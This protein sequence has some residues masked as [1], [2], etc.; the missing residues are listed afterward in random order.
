MDYTKDYSLITNIEVDDV[1]RL[2]YPCQ[3]NVKLTINGDVH[4]YTMFGP[5]ICKIYMKKNWEIPE[6]FKEYEAK[7][8]AETRET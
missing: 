6:H 4:D 8:L 3:H 5:A 1:C 2:T 7:V